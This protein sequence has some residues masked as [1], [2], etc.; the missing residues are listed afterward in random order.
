MSDA[1]D[2]TDFNLR[3]SCGGAV[4]HDLAAA[5][6]ELPPGAPEPG[7]TLSPKV[8]RTNIDGV[9]PKP[10]SVTAVKSTQ[11]SITGTLA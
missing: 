8:D 3:E 2:I 6:R 7:P 4:A 9:I 10:F 5:G 11:K 1:P